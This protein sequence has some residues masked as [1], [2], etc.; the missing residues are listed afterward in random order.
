MAWGAMRHDDW[1]EARAYVRA[2]M[3]HPKAL[4]VFDVVAIMEV[5]SHGRNAHTPTPL[6]YTLSAYCWIRATVRTNRDCALHQA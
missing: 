5:N 4:K 1:G 6:V 2:W 3:S